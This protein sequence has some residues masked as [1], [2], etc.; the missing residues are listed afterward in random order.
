MADPFSRTKI[1]K[2]DHD[3]I[4]LFYFGAQDWI[5]IVAEEGS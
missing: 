1:K 3:V 5:P 4:S 2:A